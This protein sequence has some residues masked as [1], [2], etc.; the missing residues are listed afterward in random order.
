M[1]VYFF[2][3]KITS[4]EKMHLKQNDFHRLLHLNFL[5]IKFKSEMYLEVNFSIDEL[6]PK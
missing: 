3:L 4:D 6:L 5:L 1:K 2:N